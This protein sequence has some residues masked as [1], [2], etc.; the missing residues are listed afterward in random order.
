[1]RGSRWAGVTSRSAGSD[2]VVLDVVHV[3]QAPE[4]GQPRGGV[5]AEGVEVDAGQ[6]EAGCHAGHIVSGSIRTP[7]IRTGPPGR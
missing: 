1:M 2:G 6:V 7:G 5:G 4:H 3:P